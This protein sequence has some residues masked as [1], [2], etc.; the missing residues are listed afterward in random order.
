VHGL[1]ALATGTALSG[2]ARAAE[3]SGALIALVHT[4]AAGD[5]GVVDG[6]IAALHRVADE[7]GLTPR[8]VYAADP[9]NFE[10]I[11]QL[12]GEAGAAVV[13][14]TFEEMAEPL[15]AVAELSPHA[16]RA[17]LR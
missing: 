1:A 14:T 6:M 10:P 13:F 11:L 2:P 12:L 8:A 9:S 16:L 15:K 5:N 17:N 7:R 4:Q 3:R